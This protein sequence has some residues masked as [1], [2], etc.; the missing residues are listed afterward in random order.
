MATQYPE[1]FAALAAPFD[2][3]DVKSRDQGGRQL[4]YITARTAMNRLDN[5]LGPEN[6]EDEYYSVC[7]VLFCR[8]TI[9]LPDG[10]KVSKSDAG[11]F[12]T[13]TT[14]ERGQTVEDEENTDKTGPSD[15]FKRA[16]VLLGVGRYL[17]RDGVPD[18]AQDAKA[19]QRAQQRPQQPAGAA[20][21][22]QEERR[23]PERQQA[24]GG[25]QEAR[26]HDRVPTSGRALF[27]W[28]K[29]M[30]QKHDIGLLKFLNG[31]SKLM[32]FP[33]RMVDWDADQVRQAYEEGCRKIRAIGASDAPPNRGDAYEGDAA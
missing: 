29:E 11:G 13:M 10:R 19:P 26:Q 17:Y 18:F 12:K 4:S 14:K 9:T 33:G 21:G 20:R 8:I 25:H 1:I 24:Q 16:A 7:D 3:A 6:W 2:P 28:T 32:E 27:A 5:V 31:W 22:N 23:P 30:E 15:A